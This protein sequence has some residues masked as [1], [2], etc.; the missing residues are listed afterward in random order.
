MALQMQVRR[1]IAAISA[2][3]SNAPLTSTESV[4]PEVQ[5]RAGAIESPH[6]PEYFA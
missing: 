5:Y 2:V 3:S 1:E 4:Q 6:R